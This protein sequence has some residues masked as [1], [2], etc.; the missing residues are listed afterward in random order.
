MDISRIRLLYAEA[1]SKAGKG[2]EFA[3]QL[4]LLPKEHPHRAI[5]LAYQ[6]SAEA[7]MARDATFPLTKLSHL[8]NSK[9]FF[10]DAVTLDANDPEIRM[11]RVA[12]QQGIPAYLNMSQDMEGDIKVVMAHLHLVAEKQI[13]ADLLSKMVEFVE[14][15]GLCSP[16]E[17]NQL[18]ALWS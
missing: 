15:T 17:L 7:L 8:N 5:I 9:K 11:L 6:G 1:A 16:Q 13:P 2:A 14:R 18:K 10:A 4:K 3:A 12:V